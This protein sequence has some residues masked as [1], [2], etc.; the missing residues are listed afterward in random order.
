MTGLD[1]SQFKNLIVRPTVASLALPG[2][3]E[4]RTELHTGIALVESG[5]SY[6]RQINGPALGLF[7]MEQPTHDDIWVNYLHYRP[8]L[9]ASVRSFVPLRFAQNAVPSAQ[10]LVESL[11]YSA[12][13]SVMRFLRTPIPLPKRGAAAD[14]CSAW[15]AGYNTEAG[16]GAVDYMHIALFQKAIDA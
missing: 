11:A 3:D 2:D 15:K 1:V 9:A 7:Q 4:A 8:D 14:Q 13:M 16:A 12:A 10:A 6:L 5:L